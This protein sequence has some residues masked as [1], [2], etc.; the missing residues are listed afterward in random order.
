MCLGGGLPSC[1]DLSTSSIS[2]YFI[3]PMLRAV[4]SKVFAGGSRHFPESD[5][6][7]RNV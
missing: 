6:C 2:D 1:N 7:H 4:P 3:Y 5:S